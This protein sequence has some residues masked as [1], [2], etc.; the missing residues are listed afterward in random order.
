MDPAG[1]TAWAASAR[2]AAV[3]AVLSAVSSRPAGALANVDEAQLAA[4]LLFACQLGKQ[5]RFLGTGNDDLA[6]VRQLTGKLANLGAAQ[7]GVD[8]WFVAICAGGLAQLLAVERHC[9]LAI[10]N[11]NFVAV[12][13]HVLSVPPCDMAC[14]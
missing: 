2:R 14:M 8:I 6:V 1:C 3:L 5:W 9:S 7:G 13:F 4:E 10:A 12:Q 11:Q